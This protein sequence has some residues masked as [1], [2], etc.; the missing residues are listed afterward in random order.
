LE[1]LLFSLD[2]VTWP[3]GLQSLT[4]EGLF[5]QSVENVTWPAGL[6]RL[7]FG[8]KFDQSLDNVTWPAGLQSLTFASSIGR[9]LA[10]SD[11]VL[12]GTLRT[13]VIGEMRLI[14]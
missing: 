2:N 11:I 4:F 3:A 8:R 1:E 6:Q 7:S 14:C 10:E 5:N 13:L 9:K 12:P